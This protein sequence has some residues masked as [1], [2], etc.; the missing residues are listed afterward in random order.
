[1]IVSR[2]GDD[3]E[4]V[5]VHVNDVETLPDHIYGVRPA[6]VPVF[7]DDICVDGNVTVHLRQ[8][9][10]YAH[11]FVFL[12]KKYVERVE[13][14]AVVVCSAGNIFIGANID[15]GGLKPW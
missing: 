12:V 8:A 13:E 6:I 1:M 2:L 10:P 9:P 14:E 15:L 7:D 11:S 4:K 3:I 5:I